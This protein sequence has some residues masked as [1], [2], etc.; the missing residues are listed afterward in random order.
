MAFA[1]LGDECAA[2]GVA[3]ALPAALFGF[4]EVAR[5]V[6]QGGGEAGMNR[7]L[8]GESG[9]MAARALEIAAGALIPL[10]RIFT[11]MRN[12]RGSKRA[13]GHAGAEEAAGN[14]I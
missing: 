13:K 2:K 3:G 6:A 10:Y 11:Y 7:A 1:I 4:A 5:I 8:D 12:R 14:V 9:P